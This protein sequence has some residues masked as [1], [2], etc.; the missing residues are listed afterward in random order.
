MKENNWEVQVQ[1]NKI[2]VAM[3]KCRIIKNFQYKI[4]FGI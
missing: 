4:L 1:S 2:C 3:P